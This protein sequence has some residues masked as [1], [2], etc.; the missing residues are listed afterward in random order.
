MALP[1]RDATRGW[2]GAMVVD[3]DGAEIGRCT[4]LL[5]DEATGRPEWLCAEVK[6]ASRHIPLVDAGEVDGRIRVVVRRAD[7]V[8]APAVADTH[9]L[10]ESEE[11]ALYRHYGLEYSRAASQ[12]LLPA[13]EAEPAAEGASPSSTEGDAS[14]TDSAAPSTR[15]AGRPA[16]VVGALAG[17]GAI[18][19]TVL[20]GR[21]R[22]ARRPSATPKRVTRRAR[23]FPV[24]VRPRPARRRLRGVGERA[25]RS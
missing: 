2:L 20:L 18:L 4:V 8:D 25:R 5:A 24:A 23:A 12:S 10:S 17:L 1:E 22:R 15:S 7:V 19:A 14:V 6:G 21:R 3:R 9:R 16:V 11:E 13:T